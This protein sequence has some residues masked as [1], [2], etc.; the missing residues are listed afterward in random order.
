MERSEAISGGGASAGRLFGGEK[1][2]KPLSRTAK[3]GAIATQLWP[4][5]W[6]IDTGG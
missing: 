3:R 1:Q 2:K 5:R 6:E 4:G